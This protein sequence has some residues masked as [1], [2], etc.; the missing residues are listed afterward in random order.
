MRLWIFDCTNAVTEQ[1]VAAAAEL[2]FERWVTYYTDPNLSSLADWC[3]EYNIG[4]VVNMALW[5]GIKRKYPEMAFRNHEG[6]SSFD[7]RDPIVPPNNWPSLWHPSAVRQFME[8]AFSRVVEEVGDVLVGFAIGTGTGDATVMPTNFHHCPNGGHLSQDYW[9]FDDYAIAKFQEQYGNGAIPVAHPSDDEN[10]ETLRFIQA[11]M[12]MRLDEIATLGAKYG[13]EIWPMILPFPSNSYIN[14]AA[15]YAFGLH[16]KLAKWAENFSDKH[17]VHTGFL[18]CYLFGEGNGGLQ[19]QIACATSMADPMGNNCETLVG[20]EVGGGD[21][22]KNLIR[23]GERVPKLGL[24]GL[25]CGP[26]YVTDP[27][28]KDRVK[29]ILNLSTA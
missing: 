18:F 21:W 7:S 16:R 27:S 22:E 13:V 26:T 17:N 14:M 12:I 15:G 20:A 11:G 4:L 6:M 24:H 25:L 23:N 19:D 29:V 28:N 9:V 8:P 5:P 10:F 2:G 1:Q 3:R